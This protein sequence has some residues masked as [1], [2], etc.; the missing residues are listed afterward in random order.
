MISIITSTHNRKYLLERA[1]KSV[2]AQ[3]YKEWELIIVDDCSIDGTE[4]LV[5]SFTDSRIKYLKTETNSGSDSLPKN[6]GIKEAKGEYIAFLDDDDYFRVDALKILNTYAKHTG[7]DVVYG[8]YLIDG[9]PGWSIDFSASH[10]AQQNYI[11]MDVTLSKRS[12]ILAVGGFDE[13]VKKFKDW[14]LWIRM[15]KNGASF[16]HIPIIV[17]E[18]SVQEESI[19]NKYDN[20]PTWNPAD[21]LIYP[22]KTSL[23][24]RKPL[25]VAIYT[26][27]LNR[28]AD[29][30]VMWESL[31]KTTKYPFDWFVVEQGSTDGTLDFLEG[32]TKSKVINGKNRG[33]AG[34]WNDAVKMIKSS[35]DYDIIIKVD[36][37][38]EVLSEGWLE[39]MVE[40]FERNQTIILSPYIE[41]LDGSPGGVLRAR[42]SGESP[43]LMINDKVLGFVP[44]IGGIVFATPIRLFDE[45]TFDETYEGNKDY[46]LCQYARSKGYSI[47]YMEEYRAVHQHGS[48][49]QKEVYPEYFKE[50]EG[51]E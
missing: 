35:G 7:A 24:E 44:N 25:R 1:I 14:N 29:T 16:V 38:C 32:K 19:S 30:K 43:Y 4:S 40:L 27:T 2:L 5:K 8:D 50:K 39:A 42:L 11:A 46:L 36:N 26:L 22:S 28:L 49:G 48:E 18:V 34:G 37:D 23:G 15:Q 51:K 31:Q 17:T 9:K 13:E 47:F 45:W 6:L 33:V 10:L 41:G 12:A 20:T 21:C 3:S